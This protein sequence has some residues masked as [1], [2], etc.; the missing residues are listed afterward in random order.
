MTLNS[1]DWLDQ[2]T[3]LYNDQYITKPIGEFVD[4][5]L[6]EH[7]S[8]VTNIDNQT[9][10]EYLDIGYL[11][12]HIPSVDINGKTSY[13]LVE[14]IT[15]HLPGHDGKIVK[16]MTESGRS[17]SATKSKSFLIKQNNQIVEIDG[18]K[19]QIG[20]RLPIDIKFMTNDELT[21]VDKDHIFNDV[22]MDKIVSLEYVEPSHPKVYDLTVADTRNFT[23]A[24]GLCMRDT[25][26]STGNSIIFQKDSDSIYDYQIGT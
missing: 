17:V 19:I 14:A 24:N 18:D 5:L 2:I 15:R 7:H 9:E 22:Y 4:N 25:F 16:I 23:I 8:Q 20:D 11:N 26:H 21:K 6:E 1:I 10:T 12:I 3:Y 13:K